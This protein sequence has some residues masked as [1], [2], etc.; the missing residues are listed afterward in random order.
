MLISDF[1]AVAKG[2]VIGPEDVEYD[3]GADDLRCGI[4]SASRG[5]RYACPGCVPQLNV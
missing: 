2:R 1:R 3:D 4:R 5:D